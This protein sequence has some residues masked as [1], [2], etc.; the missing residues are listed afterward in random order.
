MS[1]SVRQSVRER[2]REREGERGRE[3]E[4]AGKNKT[5]A[6]ALLVDVEVLPGALLKEIHGQLVA[7][8]N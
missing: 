8:L 6:D 3:R 5:H 7:L 1:E 4:R 2:E